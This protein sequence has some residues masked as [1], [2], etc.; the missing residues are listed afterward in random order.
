MAT[1]GNGGPRLDLPAWLTANG[2]DHRENGKVNDAGWQHYHVDCLFDEGHRGKDAYFGINEDTGAICYHCS[3]TSCKDHRWAEARARVVELGGQRAGGFVGGGRQGTAG[4]PRYAGRDTS[5]ADDFDLE[6]IRWDDLHGKNLRPEWLVTNA[7]VMGQPLLV[8]GASKT[9]KTSITLDFVVSLVT[10]KPFLGHF[11]TPKAR[12]CLMVSAESGDWT[13]QNTIN[14]ILTNKDSE[15]TGYGDYFYLSFKCPSISRPAHVEAIRRTIKQTGA[16]VFVLDPVYLALMDIGNSDS[17]SN[18]FA[19]G[20]ILR[21][22]TEMIKGEKATL[23]LLHHFR[24]QVRTSRGFSDQAASLED[25]SFSGFGEFAR[26]WIML[27][28]R[29]DFDR[30]SGVH[31]L[32]IDIGGSVGHASRWNLDVDEGRSEDVLKTDRLWAPRVYE[33]SRPVPQESTEKA[34]IVAHLR[35]ERADYRNGI[36]DSQTGITAAVMGEAN[37]ER[38]RKRIAALL[39]ALI[40]E[41]LVESIP[42]DQWPTLIG[43]PPRAIPPRTYGLYRAAPEIDPLS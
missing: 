23:V 31:E 9:L 24:K 39:K 38:N 36:V 21:D 14:R 11:N 35:R 30:A 3:H 12:R 25:F 40:E 33:Y 37:M 10:G 20:A 4:A 19:V 15:F 29:S 1:Y 43:D 7:A 6:P 13:I 26:Q 8:G 34:A 42:A 17:A 22:L 27:K 28:R 41:G 16:E 32:L 5:P 18:L 2:I